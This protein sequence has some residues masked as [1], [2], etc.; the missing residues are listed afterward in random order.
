METTFKEYKK[1][2]IKPGKVQM[3]KNEYLS[4]I[5]QPKKL[6][7]SKNKTLY[8]SLRVY[9]KDDKNLLSSK[10][11]EPPKKI[12]SMSYNNESKKD[13]KKTPQKVIKKISVK[14]N[15]ANKIKGK[16][17]YKNSRNESSNLYN[18][19]KIKQ[20]S[21]KEN[22]FYS[23]NSINNNN[24]KENLTTTTTSPFTTPVKE[25]SE[26]DK[27]DHLN[28][29]NIYFSGDNIRR[30]INLRNRSKIKYSINFDN[31][32]NNNYVFDSRP[33][34]NTIQYSHRNQNIINNNIFNIED[35]PLSNKTYS[36]YRNTYNYSKNTNYNLINRISVNKINR[37]NSNKSI[38][39][40]SNN[41][42][43][44]DLLL[45]VED[46]IMIE[47]KF[48]KLLKNVNDENINVVNKSCYEWW[49]FYFNCTLK[50]NC[51][52][53]FLDSRNKNIIT[54]H[55]SLLLISI[56]LVYDLSFNSKVFIKLIEYI[57]KILFINHQ[58][59]LNIC[60]Y[61][62]SRIKQEFLNSKWVE[63]LKE[64]LS[65]QIEHK[66]FYFNE[67]DQN[68][69]SLNQFLSILISNLNTSNII[70]NPKIKTIYKNFMKYNSDTI[71]NIFMSE[72]LKIDNQGGSLLFS[73]QKFNQPI[74][75][76]FILK[77][78]PI[79]PLTLILDL[80][81]TLMSF[82]YITKEKKE[83][84][85]RLRP[86]LYNFLNL[87]KEYYEIII[88][89][90]ATISYANPILDAIEI[91]KGKYFNYRLYRN[92]CSI[93]NNEI[94]KDINFLG[95]DISK[96]II[97]D[98][99]QQNFKLQK[100]NGILISS[101]WGEDTKDKALLYLGKILVSIATDMIS[102]NYT[103]DIRDVI[104]KYR[105]DI[106]KQVSMN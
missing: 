43:D 26:K 56:M 51:D 94:V 36:P 20:E 32:N 62:I 89:T 75:N 5:K 77:K 50:G 67:L 9:Y 23:K 100:E 7:Q 13:I 35:S 48:S 70:L 2:T 8:Q 10:E 55:N 76:D 59:F 71:N 93:V 38:N 16:I 53:L 72:I 40:D 45:N 103:C 65:S 25:N 98:N 61:L 24:D 21:S 47:D 74:R 41:N 54:C 17:I 83:G 97:V 1:H 11:I 87:V 44:L 64:I 27:R 31:N 22:I 33:E 96:V 79:K 63:L 105:D 58:N 66:K 92:H 91:E 3:T 6:P 46:L 80:D 86:F 90:A 12:I 29:N 69:Q 81:E 52:Y 106:L 15:F 39:N 57:K 49:N 99:M 102:L 37:V 18:N 14:G 82:V 34:I 85:L 73:S 104:K 4:L 30:S 68:L 95:R 88:F 78:K 84:L 19:K 101:F 28:L 42:N 60:Q